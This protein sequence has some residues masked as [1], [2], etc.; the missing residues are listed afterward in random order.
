LD[1]NLTNWFLVFARA[2]ALLAIFPAFSATN[3]PVQLRVALAALIAFLAAPF[4]PLP[5]PAQ[6]SFW[7]LIHLVFV[8]VSVGLLLGFVSRLIFFAIDM[9]GGII[10]TEMGLMLSSNFNPLTSSALP[11]PGTILFWLTMMLLFSLNLH[12]WIIAAFQHSYT[13]VPIGGAHMSEA[14]VLDL[15]RRTSEIFRIAVQMS[16][17]VM[18]VSFVIT[19]IFSVLSRA[20]PQMNVFAESF[21]IRS[22]AGLAVFGLTCNLMGQHI[23]NYLRRLPDDFLHVARL[24][25]SA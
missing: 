18:A 4:L 21:P 10:S 7:S 1:L 3:I 15:M 5:A 8:E 23:E 14:L 9:A 24:L 6:T 25:G 13:L 20:V 19:L 16:A 12:H 22:L 2:G 17:P 11:V